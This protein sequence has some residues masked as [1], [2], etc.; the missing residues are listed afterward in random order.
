[1]LLFFLRHGDPIY[2][3][4]SLTPQGRLQA[5]ALAKRLALYGLDEIYVS[6]SQRALETAQP[7]CL[8]LN[9][10]KTVLDWCNE[11][12]AWRDLTVE[13]PKGRTW[14]FSDPETRRLFRSEEV[15]RLG[16]AWYTHAAFLDTSF[17]EGI[18]RVEKETDA[19]LASLGYRHL[20]RENGYK[21]VAPNDKRVA[22][23]AH[24]GFGLAFLSCLLDVPYPLFS[25]GFDM[26]HSGMTVV[27]F[28]EPDKDGLT[29]PRVLQLSNDSHLYREGLPT[30]YQNRVRF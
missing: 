13:G 2:S 3:P 28:P 15:L 5:K 10:E 11:D 9:M 20:P 26:G 24:Q 16:K 21:A 17:K 25:T 6:S 22:L 18:L 7:T 30:C 4:N 19:F 29:F 23:F 27:E 1:M 12:Y 8:L 14:G